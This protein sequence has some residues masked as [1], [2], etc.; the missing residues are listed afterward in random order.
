M[1]S[2]EITERDGSTTE[3]FYVAHDGE[4]D[5]GP[6]ELMQ[7][8]AQA[9]GYY[10]KGRNGCTKE[11]EGERINAAGEFLYHFVCLELPNEHPLCKR[12]S[13][14]AKVAREWS[15]FDDNPEHPRS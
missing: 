11:E 7:A 3:R 9:A 2:C 14:L 6:A 1:V 15:E 13:E 10:L 5:N 8:V 4:N 12:L